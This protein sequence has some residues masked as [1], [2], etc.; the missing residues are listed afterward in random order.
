MDPEVLIN[1]VYARPPLWDRASPAHS[2]RDV[3]AGLWKEVADACGISCDLAKSKWKHLRDHFRCELKR[4]IKSR[5]GKNGRYRSSW[6]W[7]WPLVFLKEQML[8]PR[9]RDGG[10]GGGGDESAGDDDTNAL[11]GGDDTLASD[12]GGA[13]IKTEP[14]T[15]PRAPC[16]RRRS[17]GLDRDFLDLDRRNLL[18]DD[19]SLP[20]GAVTYDDTEHFLLSLAPAVRTLPLTRQMLVRLKIQELVSNEVI[21]CQE[22]GGS[23]DV[24]GLDGPS[25]VETSLEIPEISQGWAP[26][27]G[28]GSGGGGDGAGEGPAPWASAAK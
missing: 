10:A 3:V 9:Y 20:P 12:A 7:F 23:A 21:A 15:S 24:E 27:G 4:C 22:A 28:G 6:V 5:Q 19:S 8:Q 25:V 18:L 2:N 1:E 16:K 11:S 17:E 26:G 14:N 13:T